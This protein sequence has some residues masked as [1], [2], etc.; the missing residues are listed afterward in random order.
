MFERTDK[1]RIYQIINMYLSNKIDA[2]AFCDEFYYCYDLEI[3]SRNLSDI[4]KKLF[5]EL[6]IIAGRFTK[7][8]DDLKQYPGTYFSEEQLRKKVFEVQEQLNIKSQSLF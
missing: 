8:E 4:E 2:W 7:F 5:S 3:D 1:R 6:S